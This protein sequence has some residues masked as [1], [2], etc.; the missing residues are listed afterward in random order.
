MKARNVW[1]RSAN[2][3]N[4]NNVGYVNANGNCNNN[5]ANNG[6]RAAP[7]CVVIGRWKPRCSLGSPE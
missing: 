5:N 3:G 4:A 2:R 1:V 7:D 6:L